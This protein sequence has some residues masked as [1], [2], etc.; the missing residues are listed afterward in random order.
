MV[1]ISALRQAVFNR[2]NDLSV[3]RSV[4]NLRQSLKS[5]LGNPHFRPKI[6]QLAG[7]RSDLD[8]KI[9]L[10]FSLGESDSCPQTL[11]FDPD[12]TTA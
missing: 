1:Q 12:L 6:A 9:D 11:T 10:Y 5:D 7:F 3:S 2:I 4:H 8:G